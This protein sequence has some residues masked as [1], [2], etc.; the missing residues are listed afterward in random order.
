MTAEDAVALAVALRSAIDTGLVHALLAGART[1]EDH[2][3]SLCLD[4][5]A[6]ARVLDV[7]VAW[8]LATREQHAVAASDELRA[9]ANAVPGGAELML[10]V[11]SHTDQFLRTG[12]PYLRMDAGDR[13]SYAQFVGALGRMTADAARQ[14]ADRIAAPPDA[15]ILDI[16]CG[17]GV[18]SLALAERLPG[19]RVTGLDQLA[20]LDAFRARAREL[21]L[22]ERIATLAGD[23]H[24]LAIPRE[25]DVVM[26]A[27]V[28]RLETPDRAR[29]IVERGAAAVRPG[30]AL[31][32]VD[33]L[34]AGTPERERARA[35]YALHLA[36][37]T[38]RGQVYSPET[39]MA[40]MAA[41]GVSGCEQV[42]LDGPAAVGA[43]VGRASN[44]N[45]C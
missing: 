14:L 13:G 6:T 45:P 34:A 17:S 39:V 29:A 9:W 23:V 43:L 18:W 8:R 41:A 4:P 24:E 35:S 38:E 44:A 3:Q 11:W 12:R 40:W 28:L 31:V 16:G 42:P 36:M 21:G 20:V 5:R 1:P 2:A 25:Y 19:A 30:G 26:I 22:G 37:R 33:A 10:A 7:L 27:N 32:I 15:R